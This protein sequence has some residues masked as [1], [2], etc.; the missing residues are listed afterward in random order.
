MQGRNFGAAAFVLLAFGADAHPVSRI[1][2]V[3]SSA[4][5]LNTAFREVI[6]KVSSKVLPSRE[7]WDLV[8]YN[9]PKVARPYGT[10]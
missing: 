6:L 4:R 3:P 10:E 5:P 7:S 8:G 1:A 9:L 2:L